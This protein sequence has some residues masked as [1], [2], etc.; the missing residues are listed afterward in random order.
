MTYTFRRKPLIACPIEE[1]HDSLPAFS[2][3]SSTR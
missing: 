3:E 1:L 2:A